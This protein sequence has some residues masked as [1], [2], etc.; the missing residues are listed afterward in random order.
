MARFRPWRLI[1]RAALCSVIG[2]GTLSVSAQDGY[3]VFFAATSVEGEPGQPVSV[4][5]ALENAPEPVTGFSLGVTHDPEDLTIAAID[6]G[7]DLLA[8]LDAC[9][10]DSFI[11]IRETEGG[12]TAAM[13][14]RTNQCENGRLEPGRTHA[15]LD[16]TY[17]TSADAAGATEVSITS[18]LGTPSVPVLFDLG[19][20]AREATSDEGTTATIRLGGGAPFLRGDSNQDGTIGVPDAILLLAFLFRGGLPAGTPTQENCL[21]VYNFDGS[22]GAD[23]VETEEEIELNDGVGILN[24]L[25]R[26]GLLPAPPYPICDVAPGATSPRMTCTAFNCP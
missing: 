13:I 15:L 26:S 24:F 4:S 11:A 10:D 19:G 16:V 1:Q 12:F 18:D 8:V 17:T 9:R 21:L 23:G 6:I 20:V 3:S 5:I 2:I 14:L 7:V 22:T 25:F